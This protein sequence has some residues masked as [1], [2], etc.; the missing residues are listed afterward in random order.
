MI[1]HSK[2]RPPIVYGNCTNVCQCNHHFRF[3]PFLINEVLYRYSGL[4]IDYRLVLKEFKLRILS[5]ARSNSGRIW[6]MGI[7]E[8]VLSVKAA[9]NLYQSLVGS[10][11]EYG[12]EV[13]G[14]IY[15]QLVSRFSITWLGVF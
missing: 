15:G 8:G 11:L 13:W 14:L 3:G 12:S 4:E 6:N 9:I 7:K 2:K 5:K 10:G 1:F